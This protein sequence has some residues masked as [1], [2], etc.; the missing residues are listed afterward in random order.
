MLKLGIPNNNIR[1]QHYEYLLTEYQHE[2]KIDFTPLKIAFHDLAYD[3]KWQGAFKMI[4]EKYN[5][6]FLV[7]NGMEGECNLQ[8]LLCAC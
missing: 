7:R 8:G 6:V 3:G 5:E 4:T 2:A 1:R